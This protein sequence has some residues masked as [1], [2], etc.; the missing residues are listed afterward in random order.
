MH[1]CAEPECDHG[2]QAPEAEPVIIAPDPGPN[3]NDV[4]IAEIQA[5][6][7]V[8][9][10]GQIT[11]RAA[12]DAETEME[13]L[14]GEMRGMREVLDR[15]VPPEPAPVPVPVPVPEPAPAEPVAAPPETD[16]PKREKPSAAKKG[17]F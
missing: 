17:F 10:Q 11:E 5:A 1:S 2:I 12:F 16:E 3:D 9:I 6:T 8:A 4:K 7:E 14:R 15:L 13:S